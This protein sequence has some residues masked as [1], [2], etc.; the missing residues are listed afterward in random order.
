MKRHLTVATAAILMALLSVGQLPVLAAGK[1][2]RANAERQTP[3]KFVNR[4]K[5]EVGVN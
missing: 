4:L 5:Q 3:D 2:E 1:K